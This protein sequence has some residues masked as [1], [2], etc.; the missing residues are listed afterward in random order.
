MSIFAS[1]TT[2]E[3]DIP[4]D[5]PHTATIQKLT[6]RQLGKAQ[7]AFFNEL[8]AD[9]QQRGGAKVQK[10]IQSLYETDPSKMAEEVKKAKAN[11]LNGFDPYLLIAAGVKKWSY[12]DRECGPEAFEDLDAESVEFFARE[13]LRLTK[14]SLF[15]TADE[16]KAEQ[17]NG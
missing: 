5:P 11:P 13:V 6:G 9:M 7:Q 16:A 14:P 10:D 15:L 3:I 17:K 2:K 8:I 4:F 12:T 1:R